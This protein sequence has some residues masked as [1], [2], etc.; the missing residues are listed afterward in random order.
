MTY[1][2]APFDTFGLGLNLR[3]KAD[4]VQS[5]EAIDALNV[6]FTER[7]A[8]RQRDGYTAFTD[9]ALTNPVASLHAHYRAG[10]SAQLLAGCGTRL[11]ALATDG[12]VVASATGL[13]DGTWDFVRFGTPNSEV[14]YAGQGNQ[15]LRSWDGSIW[16]AVAS[17]PQAGALAV[18]A[19][20]NRI[21]A[22]RFNTTTGGPT[23]GAGT[24][25]P[26]HVYFS[27]AGS[28]TAWTTNNFVQLTPGDGEKVQGIIA[29][30]EFVFV[31]KETKFFVFYGESVASDGTPIFDYR[32]VDTGVGLASPRALAA[33]ETGVYF[34]DR[35]GVYL[36][37][38]GEPALLSSPIDPI[39]KGG[40]SDYYL[41][42]EL[43]QP[44]ITNCAMT[45]HDNHIYLAFT[46]EASVNNRTLVY[47]TSYDWWSLW[48]VPASCLCSFKVSAAPELFFGYA[49]GS[50]DVGR[51][52]STYT[53]DDGTA[54][55]SRWRSGWFDY[56]QPE[57]KTIRESK[58]WGAGKV[59]MAV[60][61]DFV[62]GLGNLDLLDFTD[63]DSYTWQSGN[64][65]I[66]NWNQAA[67][68]VA[69]LRRR[70]VRGTVFSTSFSNS[71]LNQ[72]WQVARCDHHLREARIPSIPRS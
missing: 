23:G 22:G 64:W 39:F 20:S 16:A 32:T 10:A 27:D 49:S 18:M 9:S 30:R 41:G 71:I 56:G 15:T 54:I 68:R 19:E 46:S 52:N 69:V 61:Q 25:S 58:L 40:S 62:T 63:P 36:T 5:G 6:V 60:A 2:P 21:V 45:A 70:A 50:N 11:E 65:Q 48:D 53:N 28:A 55:T 29:W 59:Y 51:H 44:D 66:G 4:A 24:S 37:T 14:S 31:F 43:D 34:L 47:H 42:G 8:V 13:T 26:S 17:T 57:Q 33:N 12:T 38:G 7:G 35:T 72:T 67:A 1:T 3:D